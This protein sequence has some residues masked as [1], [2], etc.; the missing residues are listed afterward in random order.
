MHNDVNEPLLFV[1]SHGGDEP[2]RATVPFIAAATAA[3]SGRG[4]IVICTIEG[5]HNGTP[6]YLDVQA[7]G[8][9]AL[10]DLVTTLLD[11]EG[12]IWLCSV[13]TTA[14]DITEADT[15][16]GATIV[17]AAAIVDALGSGRAITLA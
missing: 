7:P 8:T 15:I 5:V 10:A 13:C 1:C 16:E 3:V 11:N 17:G 14:R 4:A 9:P 12:E 2:E 6:A